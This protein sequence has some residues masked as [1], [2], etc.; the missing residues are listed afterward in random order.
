M[1]SGDPSSSSPAVPTAGAAGQSPGSNSITLELSEISKQFGPIQALDDVS[2]DFRGGEIHGLCGHN[3]AGKS[4][5]MR[6]IM[7]LV[8]PDA[9]QLRLDGEPIRFRNSEAAH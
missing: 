4:T 6:V 8:E 9:G 1:A 7:G 3:G 5:L 2:V